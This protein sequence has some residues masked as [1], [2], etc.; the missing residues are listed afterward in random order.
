MVHEGNRARGSGESLHT[1][2]GEAEFI[3]EFWLPQSEQQSLSE[4]R[5]IK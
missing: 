5:E 4:L 2:S 1:H 3:V